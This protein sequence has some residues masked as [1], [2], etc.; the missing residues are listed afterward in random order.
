MKGALVVRLCENFV[1]RALFKVQVQK[2][3]TE[4][5][6]TKCDDNTVRVEHGLCLQCPV[7]ENS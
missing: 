6:G 7:H 2:E 1:V 3:R 4:E 5:I